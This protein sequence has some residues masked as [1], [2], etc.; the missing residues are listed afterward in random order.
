[1]EGYSRK[2]ATTFRAY[3][4]AFKIVKS[5]TNLQPHVQPANPILAVNQYKSPAPVQKPSNHENLP[6]ILFDDQPGIRVDQQERED[7]EETN[8]VRNNE[9]G[10]LI[11]GPVP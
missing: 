9:L 11:R 3:D 5:P 7:I 10:S 6:D 4:D 2:T 1:M 8:M